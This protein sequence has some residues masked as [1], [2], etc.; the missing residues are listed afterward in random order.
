MSLWQPG[1][2]GW[3]KET[4]Q[5]LILRCYGEVPAGSQPWGEEEGEDPGGRAGGDS[6]AGGISLAV[7]YM[8]KFVLR[9]STSLFSAFL[10]LCVNSDIY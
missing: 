10:R 7:A 3:G 8:R 2:P 4:F 5:G 6:R 1:N 9:K